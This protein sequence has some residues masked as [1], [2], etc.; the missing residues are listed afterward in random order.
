MFH[1]HMMKSSSSTTTSSSSSLNN[2]YSSLTHSLDDLYGA[3]DSQNIM[4]F[5]F[6]Q[7]VLASLQSFYSEITLLVHKLHLPI[8][9]KW[10]DEYMDESARLWEVCHVLKSSISNMEIYCSMGANITSILEN[11]D[12][13][14]QIS[15]EV[16][17]AIN[18]CQRESVRLEEENKSLGET[19][20]KPLTM[21]FEETNLIHSKFNGFNGFRGALYAFKN[22]SSLLLKIMVNGLV[23]C[24]NETS[25]SNLPHI[26]T[27]SYSENRAIF[28]TDFMV[29]AARLNERVNEREDEQDGVLLKEFRET[30]NS[31]DELKRELER[32]RGFETKCDISGRV[33]NLKNC[34]GGFQCGIENTIVQLDDF[35]DEIVES[36]KK[37]LEL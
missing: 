29:S 9:E 21:K 10:L 37:L 36:R 23:Y 24:S 4:S 28:R 17:T 26:N 20:I 8:G 27:T 2:F 35:F 25:L 30:M 6:L 16:L 11:R 32:I 15:R 5:H 33:E 31:M 34:F 1:Q 13:S 19:R 18:R 12:L 22:I 14:P 7:L 3:F